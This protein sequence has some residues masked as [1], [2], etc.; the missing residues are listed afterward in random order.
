MSRRDIPGG[1]GHRK[2]Q[3]DRKPRR[4][5]HRLQHR[6]LRLFVAAAAK[7]GSRLQGKKALVFGSGGASVTVCHVSERASARTLSSSSRAPAKTTTRIWTGIS[8]AKTARSTRR[9]SACI[10]ITATSPGRSD[11]L[12]RARGRSGRGLQPRANRSDAAGRARSRYSARKRPF[13][14][15]G[16][17]EKS[18]RVFYGYGNSGRGNRPH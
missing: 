10:R 6:R 12:F 5:T 16:A 8:D 3:H 1:R 2:R 9:L 15:R 13:D 7:A 18:V 4:Q 11:A 14:A 17:G